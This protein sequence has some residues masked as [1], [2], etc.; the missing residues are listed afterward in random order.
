MEWINDMLTI[1]KDIIALACPVILAIFTYKSS[2]KEKEDA[3]YRAL[4]EELD[5]V[6]EEKKQARDKEITDSLNDLGE[7]IG[8]VEA[9]VKAIDINDI[10]SQLSDLKQLNGLNLDYSQSLSK[11]VIKMAN[12][13]KDTDMSKENKDGIGKAVEDHQNSEQ[14]I[15]K[16][17]YQFLY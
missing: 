12:C 16:K 14:V 7:K 9:A 10:Q 5:K 11:V 15:T 1:I 8:E 6:A 13:M 2:K 17:I 3:K 4:R